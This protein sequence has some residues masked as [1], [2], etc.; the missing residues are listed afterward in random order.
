MHGIAD[1]VIAEHVWEHLLYP[2][3]ATRNV[4]SMLRPGGHFLVVTPF[5]IRIHGQPDAP[6]DCSRWTETGLR[7]LLQEGFDWDQIQTWSWG[8]KRAVKRC[9]TTWA[10]CGWRGPGPNDPRYPIVVWALAR[11]T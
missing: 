1:L 6:H 2:R 10:R 9:L 11:K 8:N 4:F 7:H 5:L 3:Q